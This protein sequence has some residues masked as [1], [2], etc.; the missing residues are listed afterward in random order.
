MP[1]QRWF[2]RPMGVNAMFDLLRPGTKGFAIPHKSDPGRA[3]STAVGFLVLFVVLLMTGLSFAER[4]PGAK[5]N[6]PVLIGMGVGGLAL[7]IVG[8]I[9]F[10]GMKNRIL[11]QRILAFHD[12]ATTHG[13]KTCGYRELNDSFSVPWFHSE[14]NSRKRLFGLMCGEWKGDELAYVEGNHLIDPITRGSDSVLMGITAALGAG[15]KYK[16]LTLMG[17]DAIVFSEE[18]N[19]PDVIIGNRNVPATGYLKNAVKDAACDL[20]EMTMGLRMSHWSATS[21]PRATL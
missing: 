13:L 21:D 16:R 11:G 18:L 17:F 4:V 9:Y 12:T 3:V 5:A 19:L 7:A 2:S 8:A 20:P 10:S 15:N 14:E 1:Y 6:Y